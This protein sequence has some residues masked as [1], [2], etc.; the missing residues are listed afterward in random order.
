MLVIS[1]GFCL[2]T[3]MVGFGWLGFVACGLLLCGLL[4]L[5]C[6]LLFWFAFVDE[7]LVCDVI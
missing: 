2:L 6:G 5:D 4:G 3:S 1:V 7:C